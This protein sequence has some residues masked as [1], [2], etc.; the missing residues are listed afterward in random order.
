MISAQAMTTISAKT[1]SKGAEKMTKFRLKI[2]AE[3]LSVGSANSCAASNKIKPITH[4]SERSRET[5]F[6]V[7]KVEIMVCTLR[8]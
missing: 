7:T 4:A 3:G 1:T 8:G 6:A 2:L 5:V